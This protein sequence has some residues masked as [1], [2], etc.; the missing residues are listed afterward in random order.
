MT[1]PELYERIGSLPSGG[2][3][4]VDTRFDRGY[5]YSLIHTARAFIVSERWKANGMIPPM[6]YQKYKPEYVILS[7]DEGSCYSKFYNVPDI[8]SLDGRASGA[9]FIGG[10]GTNCQFREV[11]N[12]AEFASMMNNRLFRKLRKPVVLFLGSGEIEVYSQDNIEDIQIEA[13][14]ADPTKVSSFNVDFDQY[15]IESSDISKLELYLLQGP[16]NSI[17][18]TPMDRVNEQRDTTVSP[19]PRM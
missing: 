15:P 8:I 17:V 2:Y 14:F 19:Q 11:N 13:I 3:L 12:R 7:Q 4:T 6:Y 1:L 9:G 10:N 16:V 5:I 18:R